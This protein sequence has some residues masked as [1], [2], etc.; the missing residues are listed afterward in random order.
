[1][2]IVD[3]KRSISPMNSD[4]TRQKS[5]NSSPGMGPSTSSSHLTVLVLYLYVLT[6]C[7]DY[8]CKGDSPPTHYSI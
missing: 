6:T 2:L 7:A 3:K 5:F 4:G 1:M 8:T